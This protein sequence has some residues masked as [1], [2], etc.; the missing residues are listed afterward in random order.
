MPRCRS[1][2]VS[3][4]RLKLAGCRLTVDVARALF[5]AELYDAVRSST[6][7]GAEEHSLA[8]MSVRDLADLRNVARPA[9]Q[10]QLLPD[11]STVPGR[12]PLWLDM[13]PDD[14]E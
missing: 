8:K 5:A 9:G 1:V 10:L 11:G 13:Q 6:I 7:L 2:Y 14:E 12:V 4:A 3:R